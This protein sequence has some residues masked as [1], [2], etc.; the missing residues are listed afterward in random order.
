MKKAIAA[1]LILVAL[2]CA[3]LLSNRKIRESR[4]ERMG[5]QM[6]TS[7]ENDFES[8]PGSGWPEE[9]RS[10]SLG[11][12][13]CRGR[14]VIEVIGM[15]NKQIA[16]ALPQGPQLRIIM[17]MEEGYGEVVSHDLPE[18]TVDQRMSALLAFVPMPTN[19]DVRAISYSIHWP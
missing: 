9:F 8:L 15:V 6:M 19:G 7:I 3:V 4:A 17:G 1:C 10:T 18:S 14:S 5:R 16:E 11:Q 2:A 13:D 12:L